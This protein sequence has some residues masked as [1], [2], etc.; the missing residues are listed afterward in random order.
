M[1]AAAR[2]RRKFLAEHPICAFCGGQSHSMTIEHCPPRAMF[3]DRLWPE[4]FEFPACKDCNQGTGNQD[5]LIAMFARMNP[6]EEKGDADGR[7][8]GLMR[9]VNKQ[10]PGM[11]EKIT[12]SASE[13]R[14]HNR[15]LGLKPALGQTHQESG[16]VKVPEELHEAVCVLAKKLAKGIFYR[17]TRHIFPDEGCLLLNWFTNADLV[18]DGKYI[19]F[20]LL[21]KI[22]GE[23]PPTVRAGKYLRD[24][25][26]YKLSISPE[27]NVFILQARF[28]AAF[29]LAVFGSTIP[30]LLESG[31]TRLRDQSSRAGPF[32]V[33]QSPTMQC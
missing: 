23:V 14:R 32:A 15:E 25:F 17:E 27:Q 12:P 21:K 8:E 4:G 19:V 16:M 24:Q 10:Y 31:I 28:G 2:Y 18:R 3:Q 33:L 5:L 11:F 9:M 30:G 13:A 7:L 6:F 22:S 1:G 26:E 20:D 29:G